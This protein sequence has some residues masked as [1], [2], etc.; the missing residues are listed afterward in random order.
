MNDDSH[1]PRIYLA[2]E[3]TF[4]AW[5]RTGLALMALGFVLARVAV[6]L[7]VGTAAPNALVDDRSSLWPGMVLIV[8]GMATCIAA[9]FRNARYVRA[10]DRGAF[11]AAFGSGLG[12]GVVVLVTVVGGGIL[13]ALAP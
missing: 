7:R 11:R 2:A 6:L 13:L 1:D 5:I 4:L 12:V 10:I 8:G 9:A 3:R